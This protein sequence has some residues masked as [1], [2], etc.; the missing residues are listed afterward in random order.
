M[1]A[2]YFEQYGGPEVLKYGTFKD[3]ALGLDEVLISV[4][5]CSLNHLDIWIRQG[6]YKGKNAIP[7]PHILGAD[8][9]GIVLDTGRAVK[10]LKKGDRVVVSPGQLSISDPLALQSMDSFSPDF[11]I[12]GLQS[13]GGYAEKV[14]V[15]SRFVIPVSD[16]FSFEEWSSVLLASLTAYHMLTTRVGVKAGETVLVQA[17]GSGVGR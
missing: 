12:L 14:A 17:A 8:V 10:H 13:Q 5:A 1:R 16:R 15:H 6:T 4:K 9:A 2:I 11:Q 7:M 3:P